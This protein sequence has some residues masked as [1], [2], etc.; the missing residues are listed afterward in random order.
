VI[1]AG[2]P[3]DREG[4]PPGVLERLK[5]FVQGD[6]I[7]APPLFYW[8]D[9]SVAV[10]QPTAAAGI[11]EPD[12][13]VVDELADLTII[14]SQT[15]DIGEEDAATPVKPF[16]QVAPVY[17]AS[18]RADRNLL[19]KRKGP[20]YLLHLPELAGGFFVADFRLEMPVEKGWL[21]EQPISKAFASEDAQEEVGRRLRRLRERPAFSRRFMENIAAPLADA[22]RALRKTDRDQFNRIVRNVDQIRVRVDSRLNTTTAELFV[23][24]GTRV[25]GDVAEWFR[26]WWDEVN[27]SALAG[28]IALQALRVVTWDDMTAREYDATGEVN[29]TR[30]SPD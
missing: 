5:S 4:W 21:S 30:W 3:A 29:L 9:P 13:V 26:D 22:I 7:P 17:D 27:Q 2:L 11:D 23:V 12:V 8:A 16:V 10:W 25:P 24:G 20:A 6:V 19:E 14:T 18:G 28:G 1:G 15:C